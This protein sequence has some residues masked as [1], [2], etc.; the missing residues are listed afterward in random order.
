MRR[1]K[2]LYERIRR[3]PKNVKYNELKTLLEACGYTLRPSSG[4]SH[5]WFYK[6]GCNPIH[7]PEHR[8]LGEV[9]GKRALRVIEECIDFDQ[10]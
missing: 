2:K 5:R 6:K 4:G 10:E 7:F 3:N 9:Y 1:A 8:P